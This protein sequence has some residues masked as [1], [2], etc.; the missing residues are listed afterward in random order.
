MEK[1]TTYGRENLRTFLNSESDVATPHV[2][3]L[4][5]S[6][7]SMPQ[8]IQR[9]NKRTHAKLEKYKKKEIKMQLEN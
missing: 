3:V 5:P 4:V 2:I 8:F 9:G 7:P 6:V 1:D